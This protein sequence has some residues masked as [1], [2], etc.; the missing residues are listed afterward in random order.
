MGNGS[1]SSCRFQPSSQ[2][3][4]TLLQCWHSRNLRHGVSIAAWQKGQVPSEPVHLQAVDCV[5][6]EPVMTA[7]SAAHVLSG[8]PVVQSVLDVDELSAS[9]GHGL[10]LLG[11]EGSQEPG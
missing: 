6:S 2:V 5:T 4:L 3:S 8:G 7:L 11:P 9:P 10:D 1:P